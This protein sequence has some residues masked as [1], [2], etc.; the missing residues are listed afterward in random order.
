[1]SLKKM[2]KIIKIKNNL[3][4]NGLKIRKRKKCS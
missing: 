2:I 4:M 3:I 1:M